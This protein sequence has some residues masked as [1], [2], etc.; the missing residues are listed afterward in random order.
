VKRSLTLTR[1]HLAELSDE[2][3][4]AVAGA[5]D[6]RISGATCPVLECV[7]SRYVPCTV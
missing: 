2:D 6:T 5:N 3:L 7:N 4:G 1:E